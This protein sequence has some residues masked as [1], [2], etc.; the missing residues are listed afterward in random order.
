[1]RGLRH[2]LIVLSVLLGVPVA[3]LAESNISPWMNERRAPDER[4]Q[5]LLREM[6][7]GEKLTLVFGYFGN[8]A[9]WKNYTPPPEAQSQ[10]AGYVP[11][12]PRLGIPPQ[13]QADAGIGVASQRGPNPRL[14]TALPSGL[15]IAATWDPEVAFAGG[16][17]IG[18]EARLS[19]FNVLLA[20]ALNLVR[21]PRGGRTFEYAGEDPW[22]SAVM[23][24]AQV[25]GI[26]SN[27][28]IST[29]KH[30]ALND[31]ETN[32]FKVSAIIDDVP[33]RMSDLL[34]FQFA[35]EMSNPGSIMTAYNQ[36]NG[37]F[38]SDHPWLLD[39]VLKGD[40]DYPGYVMSDW[41]GLHST[42]EAA[43]AGFD[44]QSGH[45]FD[46]Q[47]YFGEPLKGAVEKGE[48]PQARLDDMVLRILR[49]MFAHGLIDDPV[50]ERENKIDFGAHNM[51]SRKAAEEGIVLLKNTGDILPLSR[52]L[53][54]IA[55][56][57]SYSDVGVMSGGGASQVYPVG[58][59]AVPGLG[60]DHFP[61]PLVYFPS[62]PVK[63][64][65]ART[66]ATVSYDSGTD[67]ASAARLA[68]ESDV[69]IVF[70]SE[71]RAETRDNTLH[72]DDEQDALIAA[73]AAA[74]PK[75]IVVLE[76][77]GA[78]LMPW[79]SSVA[80][81]VSAWYPGTS[82]GEA[83]ARVLSGE[84]NPS[85][86]LPVTFPQSIDQLPRPVV[87]DGPTV[88]YNIDGA[89]VGHK[90]FDKNGLR[91]L[92]PFGF[93][94]SYTEFGFSGL[95]ARIADRGIEAAFTVKNTGQVAGEAVGQVY[96]SPVAGGWEAPKRLGG[97]AK[98][99]L[100]PGGSRTLDVTVD[101][102]LLAVYDGNAK[103]WAI[104][105]GDYR[106]VLATDAMTEVA[107]V[108]IRLPAQILDMQG[109]PKAR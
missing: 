92:F 13:W 88:D 50:V 71:W 5:L 16:A 86:R 8:D 91:P 27:H 20:G 79:L 61:G 52:S 105:A 104:A 57:G 107:A 15:A 25:N 60:P 53:K 44:Q 59:V 39:E 41:G 10:S 80:A 14:R 55:V 18:N 95:S 85:G 49:S 21:E 87:D 26:Q 89:A 34:A 81:V 38:A 22:H 48:V 102:R 24:A 99:H 31:Q 82:G 9:P 46:P 109:N 78:I 83:I 77:G 2:R 74:N 7:Q 62:S 63:E 37:I 108:T 65:A 19:G 4:A 54:S 35:I 66:G 106:V 101:P 29:L 12:V 58:G 45:P 70:G 51:V 56:I 17:M 73:V 76:T 42:V 75:T 6:T 28:I 72:L 97:F 103:H 33:A 100:A 69:A 23:V 84:V 93:G 67:P 11:G 40:W 64:I 98:V 94:L 68:R 1:M 47:P 96:V 36:V 43:N 32:R 3:A 90:W 30:F